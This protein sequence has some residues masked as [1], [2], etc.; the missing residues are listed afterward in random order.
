[1]L[2]FDFF[3]ILYIFSLF[4]LFYN[5]KNTSTLLAHSSILDVKR[6]REDEYKGYAKKLTNYLLKSLNLTSRAVFHSKISILGTIEQKSEFLFTHLFLSKFLKQTTGSLYGSN[7]EKYEFCL[8]SPLYFKI[9]YGLWGLKPFSVRILLSSNFRVRTLLLKGRSL[10]LSCVR[11][12]RL[13]VIARFL[14]EISSFSS[15]IRTLKPLYFFL[16]SENFFLAVSLAFCKIFSSNGL[17]TF[18]NN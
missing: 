7:A 15:F 5:L 17:F 1:M 18:I 13:F 2:V 3:M 4:Y 10:N 11:W 12:T 16:L 9:L 8:S 14:R 6:Y